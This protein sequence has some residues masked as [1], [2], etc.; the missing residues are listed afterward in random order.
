MR[1]WI[2]ICVT[3]LW[4][5]PADATRGSSDWSRYQPILERRPFAV[6][7]E[8]SSSDGKSAAASQ[9]S[10]ALARDFRLCTIY[11]GFDGDLRAGLIH[12]R[13]KKSM[14]LRMGETREGLHLDHVDL[15]TGCITLSSIDGRTAVLEL[16]AASESA[17]VPGQPGTGDKISRSEPKEKSPREARKSRVPTPRPQLTG[18]ELEQHLR[19]YQMEVLRKGQPPL[20]IPLTEEMDDQLVREG[21]LPPR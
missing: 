5:L 1:I 9:Q 14:I 3:V 18:E 17:P 7:I 4:I 20:P 21:V 8:A 13:S 10:E 12:R 16:T 11:E 19:E 15:Q 6:K 2:T